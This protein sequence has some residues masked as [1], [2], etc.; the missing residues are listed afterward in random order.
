MYPQ[1]AVQGFD[2]LPSS[3]GL[4]PKLQYQP[5]I[6]TRMCIIYTYIC[7]YRISAAKRVPHQSHRDAALRR[8]GVHA[9]ACGAPQPS[10]ES[11]SPSPF[12]GARLRTDLHTS[13]CLGLHMVER[14]CIYIYI[15][16]YIRV[17]TCTHKD[18]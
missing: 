17:L 5:I 6:C 4:N 12:R 10:R 15:Y 13:R 3:L 2:F 18:R 14:Y 7:M 8:L 16:I 11:E 1:P 9:G